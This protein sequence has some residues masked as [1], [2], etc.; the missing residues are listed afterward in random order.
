MNIKFT[1]ISVAFCFRT[2]PCK[3]K[4]Y[5]CRDHFMIV[6]DSS[7]KNICFHKTKFEVCKQ[8]I[9]T[10]WIFEFLKQIGLIFKGES[11]GL[12]QT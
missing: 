4:F 5:D 12:S 11:A 8:K 1:V 9:N 7:F 6:T 10:T 2:F 3:M